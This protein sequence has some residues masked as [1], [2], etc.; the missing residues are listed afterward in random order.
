MSGAVRNS[1]KSWPRAL[2]YARP[3]WPLA[4]AGVVLVVAGAGVSLLEPWPMAVLVDSV[5]GDHPLPAF[6]ERLTGQSVFARVAFAVA[7]GLLVT[8]LIHAVSVMSEFVTTKLGLRMVLEFRSQLFQHVQRLSFS[9]HD[10]RRTGSFM[11]IINQEAATVGTVTVAMFPLLQSALTLVGMFVIA[12]RLNPPVA[13]VSLSVVPFIY[14][15]TGYYGAKIGPQV[16][17]VRG[18]EMLSLHIVHETVQMLRVIVAFNREQHEYGKFRNQGEE[19]VDARVR[20]TVR[21]TVF[22]LG[23]SLVTAI[24]TALVLGVGAFQVLSGQLTVGKLL[25]L[26]SYIAAVYKPLE[27]ISSTINSIQ[28]KLVSFDMALALLNASPEVTEK[29]DAIKVESVRGAV[30]F[31]DVAFSYSGRDSTLDEISFEVSPGQTLAIVGPT[32][33]G[34]STLASLLPRFYDPARGQVL[35]DGCDLRDLT[36]ESL[37]AQMSIVL[38]EPLL[39]TGTIEDNICYGKL[40]ASFDEVVKAAKRA[41]AHDFIMRLPAKYKTP[42]GERGAKISGG[43]R[44]RICIARAFLKDAPILILDEPTSSIDSQTEAVILEALDKLMYGR[45]TFVIAHR[46][47]TIRNADLILV[48]SKGRIQDQG[49]HEELIERGGLYSELYRSQL[50]TDHR[51][52]K[53]TS[54]GEAPP[55]DIDREMVGD[56]S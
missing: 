50:H 3:Y 11:G 30:S 49:T 5:L 46:L 53:S 29:P 42:L 24:G 18:M 16:R 36:L 17:R 33:A 44:Q 2:H 26:V 22:N 51:V 41:N 47:S 19:A 31:R 28:E 14:Y 55:P 9:Y 35:L 39:F 20:L 37:R 25:V 13:L 43:E 56:A 48:L 27:K 32:G 34:K 1:L 12:F 4:L 10:N 8:L 52:S 38:Q 40:D 21:Q 6:F 7:M 15:S 54:N 23:V 45:T